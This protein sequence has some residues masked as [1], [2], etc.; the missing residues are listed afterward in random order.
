MNFSTEISPTWIS[1]FEIHREIQ[2]NMGEVGGSINKQNCWDGMSDVMSY[3]MS[4]H[5]NT[6]RKCH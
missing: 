5:A 6:H 1:K 3:V 2:E 4:S